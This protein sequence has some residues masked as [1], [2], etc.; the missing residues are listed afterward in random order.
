MG[1]VSQEPLEPAD[2]LVIG[3]EWLAIGPYEV[4]AEIAR[5]G[6]GVVYL[7]RR[8]GEAGFERL[9][10]IK[11]MHRHLAHDRDFVAMLLDEGRLAARIHHH[12]VASVIELGR[13]ERGHYLVM[14]YVEGCSLAQLLGANPAYRPADLLVPILIGT[15]NGLHAAHSVEDGDGREA[16]LIHRDLSPQNILVGID[17]DA[18]I[19]DFGVARARARITST[20]PGLL[21][22]K[23]CY[24]APE[25][26][27]GSA[28]VDHRA[29]QFSAG[30]VLWSAL[31]GRSLFRGDS[32][33]ETVRRILSLDVVP[34]STVGLAPQAVFDA[35]ILTALARDPSQRFASAAAMAEALRAAALGAGLLGAPTRVARW[36][37]E[38]FATELAARHRLIREAA[39]HGDPSEVVVLPPLVT[40]MEPTPRNAQTVVGHVAA[41]PAASEP[42]STAGDV[43]RFVA[44]V[45]LAFVAGTILTLYARGLL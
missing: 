30:A 15:L 4:I 36:V 35:I 28:A 27:A 44:A 18:R 22:G 34:P 8:A 17:G 43:A 40:A 20:G 9:F 5:G 26:L 24:T 32:D 31:T 23:I 38:T 33:A 25:I 13:T 21:K 37:S 7:C 2:D 42:A 39:A 29:D 10:A 3:A 12:N 41:T 11:E 14:P 6:M 19:T 1:S 16:G 45:M